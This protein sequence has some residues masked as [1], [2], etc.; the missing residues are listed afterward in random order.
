[1]KIHSIAIIVILVLTCT[2]ENLT[3][4]IKPE[5]KNVLNFGYGVNF[6]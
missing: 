4:D 5:L 6:K 1:M 2:Y 3:I